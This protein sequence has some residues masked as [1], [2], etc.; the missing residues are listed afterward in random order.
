MAL[1]EHD[2]VVLTRIGKGPYGQELAQIIRKVQQEKSSLDNIRKGE[3]YGPQV[4][5][6]LL[7]KEF[8]DELVE[9]LAFTPHI[10]KKRGTDDYE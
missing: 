7:F 3:D 2:K 4:E 5:G 10:P 9:A 1:S 8:V 6:R